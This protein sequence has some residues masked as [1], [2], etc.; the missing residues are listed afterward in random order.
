MVSKTRHTI[1]RFLFLRAVRLMFISKIQDKTNK[2]SKATSQVVSSVTKYGAF[3]CLL[4]NTSFA[5]RLTSIRQAVQ[6]IS[7][8]GRCLTPKLI[9]GTES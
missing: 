9:S 6:C 1:E 2:K 7:A 3:S 8:V 5:A 4:K